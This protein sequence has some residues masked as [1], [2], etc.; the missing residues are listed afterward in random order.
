MKIDLDRDQMELLLESLKSHSLSLKKE[1]KDFYEHS[2]EY[3]EIEEDL[4]IVADLTNYI[5]D[6]LDG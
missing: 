5:Q 4:E 2:N 3:Y 6:H 1:K